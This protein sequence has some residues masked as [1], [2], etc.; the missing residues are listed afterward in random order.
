M[1]TSFS[2]LM[3]VDSTLVAL[4]YE[5]ESTGFEIEAS[6]RRIES[7]LVVI[8]RKYIAFL[9]LVNYNSH[10]DSLKVYMNGEYLSK[11]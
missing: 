1:G 3:N 6:R 8:R 5:I 9:V 10:I 7:R 11:S 4:P 2:G